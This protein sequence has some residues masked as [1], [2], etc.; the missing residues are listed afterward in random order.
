LPTTLKDLRRW[1]QGDTT[2]G[3]PDRRRIWPLN[4]LKPRAKPHP[5]RKQY[6]VSTDGQD[7]LLLFGKYKG[8]LLRD[9][10]EHDPAYLR[11][12][13]G[14]DFPEELRDIAQVQLN[15]LEPPF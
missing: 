8:E 2:P 10:V 14:S 7:A 15:I 5:G 6:K 3:L 4:R 12:L 9:V 11:W 13:V 1:L